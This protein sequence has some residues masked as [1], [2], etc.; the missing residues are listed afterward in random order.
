MHNLAAY[1]AAVCLV[2]SS[3]GVSPFARPAS[4]PPP[5]T[6]HVRCGGRSYQYELSSPDQHAALP[7]ILLLHGAGGQSSDLMAPW[8]PLA[9]RERVVLIAPQ[10]PRELW[11]EAVAPAVFRCV[12]DDARRKVGVDRDRVYLFGYSMGGYL[13]FDGAMLAS[14]YFAAAAV[15]AA[16]IADDYYGIV[17]SATRKVPVALYVGERDPYYPPA[18]VQRTR[19]LLASKE[20]PVRYTEF[21]GQDH[22]YAPVAAQLNDDAWRFLSGYRLPAR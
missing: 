20:F 12:V 1:V 10:I 21:P 22:A 16:A 2:S 6:R 14:D 15:Y 7:A 17:D 11:F 18:K 8:G 5:E 3:G 19:D 9:A 13:A 4:T